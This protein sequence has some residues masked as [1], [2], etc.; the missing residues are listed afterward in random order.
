MWGKSGGV[1]RCRVPVG[2]SPA[3]SGRFE[4]P[5][6]AEEFYPYFFVPTLRLSSDRSSPLPD[7]EFFGKFF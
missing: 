1:N 5:L 3:R 6:K 7:P 4:F 2:A